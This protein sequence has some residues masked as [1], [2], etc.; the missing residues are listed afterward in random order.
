MTLSFEIQYT[1]HKGRR[2]EIEIQGWENA[3][4]KAKELAKQTG[5][6]TT[7]RKSPRRSWR[8]Y[9]IRIDDC[10][11]IE[12][13]LYFTKREAI[14]FWR[15]WSIQNGGVCVFWPEYLGKLTVAD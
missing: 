11:I 9:V 8:L 10:K 4:E 3:R 6:R 15:Q 13:N 1:D 2:Q 5:K 7:I 12:F 14:D